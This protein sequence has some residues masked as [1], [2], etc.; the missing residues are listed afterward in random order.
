MTRDKIYLARLLALP[1][2]FEGKSSHAAPATA[3]ALGAALDA[4]EAKSQR[5]E[6]L[7]ESLDTYGWHSSSCPGDPCVCGYLEMRK[8]ANDTT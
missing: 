4:L 3:V 7:Q 1:A 6:E 8:L 2:D 5:V